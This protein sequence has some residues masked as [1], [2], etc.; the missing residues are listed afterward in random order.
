MCDCCDDNLTNLNTGNDGQSAYL[1]IIYA[2]DLIGTDAQL[3]V[4]TCF[5]AFVNSNV[6]M[7]NQE[8]IDYAIDNE[9]FYDRCG[10]SGGSG[11]EGPE[12]PA[13]PK[14]DPGDPACNPLAT[15]SLRFDGEGA[16][17]LVIPFTKT[18]TDCNQTFTGTVLPGNFAASSFF[19]EV[20]GSSQFDDA[21]TTIVNAGTALNPTPTRLDPLTISTSNSTNIKAVLSGGIGTVILPS[22]PLPTGDSWITYYQIGN[23]MT[24]NF[25]IKLLFDF[26][27]TATQNL[28]LELKIPNSKTSLNADYSNAISMLHSYLDISSRLFP[29]ITTNS[30][31]GNT[32]LLISLNAGLPLITVK[33]DNYLHFMGQF[34]F[35]VN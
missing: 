14:G 22:S 21:V 28:Q 3:T 32:H 1:Y 25:R 12:G 17:D 26:E 16:E 29:V 9:L 6:S 35:P 31:T 11:S 7:T 10:D 23:I 30:I 34:S 2:D 5:Q 19:F 8:A 18:G 4:P 27:S 15:I 24:I 20:L 33:N 13:G